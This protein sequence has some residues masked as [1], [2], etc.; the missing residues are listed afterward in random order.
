MFRIACCSFGFCL[1]A[2][3]FGCG[4]SGPAT[5]EVTGQVTFDGQPVAEGEILLRAADGS[6]GSRAGKIVDGRYT[7]QSTVG[8]KRVEINASREVKPSKIAESGEEVAGELY[9]PKK[10][11]LESE[12]TAEVTAAGPN[13]FDFK[14]EP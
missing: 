6:E 2:L 12:L 5:Y 3:L 11:N 8:K 1:V 7:I 4:S 14:L 9:I 10:Y 13:Q